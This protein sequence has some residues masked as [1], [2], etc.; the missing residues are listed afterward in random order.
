MKGKGLKP[1]VEFYFEENIGG[2]LLKKTV[3]EGEN[4]KRMVESE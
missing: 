4:L 1:G 3:Q 2:K